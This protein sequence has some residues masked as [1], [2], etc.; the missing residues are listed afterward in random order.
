MSRRSLAS[1]NHDAMHAIK[2]SLLDSKQYSTL[3]IA[4]AIAL[5]YIWYMV[6]VILSALACRLIR[7]I[8]MLCAD[9]ETL[10]STWVPVGF[11]RLVSSI[12]QMSSISDIIPPPVV[13]EQDYVDGVVV[14]SSAST[15]TMRLKKSLK[16]HFKDLR[17][18]EQRRSYH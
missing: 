7:R 16:A 10:D 3:H 9:T 5:S 1:G 6:V 2:S 13:V 17:E 15:G 14:L 18:E 4:L 11:A 12:L 8:S